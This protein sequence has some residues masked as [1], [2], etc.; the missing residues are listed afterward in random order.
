MFSKE[1]KKSGYRMMKIFI[2]VDWDRKVSNISRVGSG[3]NLIH[4]HSLTVTDT[5]MDVNMVRDMD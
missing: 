4:V 3:G 5:V 2:Q 1:K